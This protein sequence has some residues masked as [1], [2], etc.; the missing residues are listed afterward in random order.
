MC[1]RC[2]HYLSLGPSNDAPLEVQIE[3]R[4][5]EIA[6]G[7][8]DGGCEVS[9]FEHYGFNGIP[10]ILRGGGRIELLLQPL[11]AGYLAKVIVEHES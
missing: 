9:M 6:A 11:Q 5:A 10:V 3:I 4:A 2:S 8:V 7:L 1:C